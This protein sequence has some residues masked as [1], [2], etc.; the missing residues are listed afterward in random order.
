MQEAKIKPEKGAC[1][2]N[3]LHIAE[4]EKIY[5]LRRGDIV[6]GPI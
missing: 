1:G 5:H 4:R 3:F 2:I 6:F